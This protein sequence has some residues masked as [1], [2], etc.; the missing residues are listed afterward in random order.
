MVFV[1]SFMPD[2]NYA[3]HLLVPAWF[4]AGVKLSIHR[5]KSETKKEETIRMTGSFYF[6]KY[7]CSR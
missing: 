4:L 5:E 3:Q 2:I 7:A 1:D 6:S